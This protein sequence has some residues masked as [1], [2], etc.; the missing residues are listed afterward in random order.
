MQSY[1]V[2]RSL[3]YGCRN[4]NKQF[5]ALR[6][7]TPPPSHGAAPDFFTTNVLNT[8]DYSVG[9][10][11]HRETIG[12]RMDDLVGLWNVTHAETFRPG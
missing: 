12:K 9:A 6:Y 8:P 3:A 2:I 4:V 5:S 7:L 11:L 10:I 1:A